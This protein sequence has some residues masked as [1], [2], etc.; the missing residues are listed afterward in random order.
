M[1]SDSTKSDPGSHSSNGVIPATI[2][3]ELEYKSPFTSGRTCDHEEFLYKILQSL[4][5]PAFQL[6]THSG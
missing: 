5:I 1:N 3:I 4:C 2:A 6:D